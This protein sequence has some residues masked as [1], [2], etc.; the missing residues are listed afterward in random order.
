M[1]EYKLQFKPKLSIRNAKKMIVAFARYGNHYYD[2]RFK[3]DADIKRSFSA[4]GIDFEQ[5]V[6]RCRDPRETVPFFENLIGCA[7][8][9]VGGATVSRVNLS[10]GETDLETK[11]PGKLV[12]YGYWATFETAVK[13]LHRAIDEASYSE[14]Q[15][16]IVQG[17]A[18]IEGYI[19]YRADIWN[20]QHPEEQLL[21]SRQNKVGFDD[22]IGDWIPKMT[23]GRKLYKGNQEW[24]HFRIL[25]GIR[26]HHAIHPKVSGYSI[27]FSE[28]AEK[29]N[30]FR[31]GIAGLLIQL[32]ILFREKVPRVI[33]RAAYAPDVEVVVVNQK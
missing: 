16:A 26:D 22:K 33:I 31:T 4:R 23:G 17:V 5:L 24:S 6:E 2:V 28:L 20:K 32:H 14:L 7:A 27:S 3:S 25:R 11:S 21:D 9:P 30:M 10:T 29:I 15:S 8:T 1:E 12:L 13:A 18:S 19:N